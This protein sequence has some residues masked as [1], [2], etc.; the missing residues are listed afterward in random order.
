M[1]AREPDITVRLRDC[2]DYTPTARLIV[3]MQGAAEI[4][5]LRHR[6]KISHAAISR[7]DGKERC[8]CEVCR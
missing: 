8:E 5:S 6:L 4:E 7:I 2:A 3:E 1:S